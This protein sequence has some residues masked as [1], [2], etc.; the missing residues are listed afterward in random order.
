[1]KNYIITER[2]RK[3]NSFS[4]VN[5][6]TKDLKDIWITNCPYKIDSNSLD[7]L[8]P[9]VFNKKSDA[10]K[11]LDVQQSTSNND[12][13]ENSHIYKMHGDSKP[14]WRIEEYDGNLFK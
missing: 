8:N 5:G 12:W 9:K 7:R 11:Y 13:S 2:S 3:F 4:F 6:D 1:M 14:K 10:Y